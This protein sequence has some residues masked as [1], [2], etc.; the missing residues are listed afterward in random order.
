MQHALLR[1]PLSLQ[2]VVAGTMVRHPRPLRWPKSPAL[3]TS[4]RKISRDGRPSPPMASP[5]AFR[6]NGAYATDLR[7]AWT[8]RLP[9]ARASLFECNRERRSPSLISP[10][11]H[12]QL[13]RIAD[14]AKSSAVTRQTSGRIGSTPPIPQVRGGTNQRYGLMV[15]RGLSS[16]RT[17][18]S[19]SS[20]PY[21]SRLRE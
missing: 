2:S 14:S 4:P 6:G 20:E 1:W 9:G 11:R 13:L 7:L 21:D 19:R 8:Q 5:S 18:N 12:R 17:S 3:R 16:R 15:W 10:V